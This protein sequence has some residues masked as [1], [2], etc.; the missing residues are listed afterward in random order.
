[1]P[2]PTYD[3]FVEPILRYLGEHPEGAIARDAHEAIAEGLGLTDQDKAELL[4]SGVQR[5]YKNRASWA[6]HRLK[7]AGLSSSP[8]RGFWRVTDKGLAFLKEHPNPLSKQQVTEV[9]NAYFDVH[10][11]PKPGDAL[12]DN[13]S[14]LDS[15]QTERLHDSIASPDDRLAQAEAE[16]LEAIATELLETILN[17]SSEFFE[18]L[19]LHLLYAMGYGTSRKDLQR[20]GRSGDGGIDGI[21]SLDRLGLEKIYIQAKRWNENSVSRSHVQS[22]YGAVAG[23]GV[24]KG[25]FITTSSFSTPAIEFAESIEGIVL[26][27]GFRLTEL[28][29]E[30]NVG[31][32]HRTMKI[33]K[34]DTD[35]F[36]E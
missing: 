28:M 8:K 7:H 34:I 33:P 25:V 16:I 12:A 19:V 14:A 9:V 29:I 27:G 31:V 15:V 36:E 30:H 35:Y 24:N 2:V 18:S 13:L 20:V 3:Q 21:I 17:S 11:R 5:I 22:F 23:R 10:P 1:M 6:H 26:I 32:S 4:P